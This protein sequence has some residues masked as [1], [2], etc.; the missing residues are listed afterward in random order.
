ML[1]TINS[2]VYMYLKIFTLEFK[3]GML[4]TGKC[5]NATDLYFYLS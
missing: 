3:Y 1:T 4:D 2:T 5:S